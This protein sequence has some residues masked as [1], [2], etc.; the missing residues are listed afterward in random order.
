MQS[1][2]DWMASRTNGRFVPQQG[3]SNNPAETA[4][5]LK[6]FQR[7]LTPVQ[8]QPSRPA[9]IENRSGSEYGQLE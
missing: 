8:R 7:G 1:L 4:R 6:D 3:G 5:F 9:R 2:L